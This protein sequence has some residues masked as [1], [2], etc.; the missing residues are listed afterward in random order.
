MKFSACLKKK[1]PS[2]KKWLIDSYLNA[3][4]GKGRETA[5]MQIVEILLLTGWSV[6]EYRAQPQWVIDH[7]LARITAKTRLSVFQKRYGRK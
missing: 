7:I 6:E 3:F 5:Q 4:Q 2:K 1:Q